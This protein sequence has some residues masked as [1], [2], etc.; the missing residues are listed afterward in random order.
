[1]GIAFNVVLSVF[2]IKKRLEREYLNG[3]KGTSCQ[4]VEKVS[5]VFVVERKYGKDQKDEDFLP[6]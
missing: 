3:M 6:L 2:D 4:Y 5:C 1:L